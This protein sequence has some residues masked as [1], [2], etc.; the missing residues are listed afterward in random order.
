[1]V[2]GQSANGASEASDVSV[3]DPG[4][5]LSQAVIEKNPK[6]PS[7]QKLQ[8]TSLEAIAYALRLTSANSETNRS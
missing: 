7:A 1:L 6:A 2:A 4:L 5:V 8:Q 3:H